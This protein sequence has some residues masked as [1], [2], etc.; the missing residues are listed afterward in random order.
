M[1]HKLIVLLLFCTSSI[2]TLKTHAFLHL[3]A[4]VGYNHGHYEV[5]K[6]QGIGWS[7][8]LGIQ[9]S[10]FFILADAGVHD[11]Q[12]IH[13]PNAEYT[14]FGIAAG[15]ELRGWRI[16]ITQ[17]LN[18]ELKINNTTSTT[19]LTG[20]GLKIGLSGRLASSLF[21]NLESRFIEFNE[22]NKIPTSQIMDLSFLSLSWVLL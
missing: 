12:L 7:G 6:A 4:G 13:V 14:D 18:T 20:E 5:Q 17:I 2:F 10:H 9:L 19:Q 1:I 11:L 15:I 16:W 22:S 8:K 21:I 3:E